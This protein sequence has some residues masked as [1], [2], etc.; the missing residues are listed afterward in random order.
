M[1]YMERMVRSGLRDS[2]GETQRSHPLLG[3]CILCFNSSQ[4]IQRCLES[5]EAFAPRCRFQVLVVDNHSADETPEILKSILPATGV[6]E[7]DANLGYAQ[8]NNAGAARL[9]ELGCEYI[10][11]VNPD[12]VLEERSLDRMVELLASNPGA[13]VVGGQSRNDPPRAFRKKCGLLAWLAVYNGLRLLSGL[14]TLCSGPYAWGCRHHYYPPGSLKDGDRVYAVSGACFVVD[15][16]AFSTAGMFDP[17]T[18]L[19]CEE[20]ILSERM[21]KLGKFALACPSAVY[22]HVGGRSSTS[23][24]P[25]FARECGRESEQI[26][27]RDY[28]GWNFRSRLARAF[29]LIERIVLGLV[30]SLASYRNSARGARTS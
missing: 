20:L 29:R 10:A 11:F 16:N 1:L 12:V 14:R 9:A 26:L 4:V 28:Y 8:G 22:S 3:I 2:A 25:R 24:T 27:F 19:F 13:A 5:L 23:T 7:L 6:L 21:I 17:R 18:F 30:E 15:A